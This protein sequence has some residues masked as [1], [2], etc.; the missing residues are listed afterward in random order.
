MATTLRSVSSCPS[1]W[2]A[3]SSTVQLGIVAPL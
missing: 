2:S 3:T 1:S